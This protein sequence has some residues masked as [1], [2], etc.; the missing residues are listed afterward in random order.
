M[1][2]TI[3]LLLL[4]VF[5]VLA[6]YE[7]IKKREVYDYLNFSLVFIFLVIGIFDSLISSSIEPIKYV[8]FGLLIGFFLGSL[9]YYIGIW[10][11]GDAKFMLGFGASSYYIIN[12]V[13]SFSWVSNFYTNFNLIYGVYIE[14]FIEYFLMFILILDA[15]FILLIFLSFLSTSSN[16]ERKKN[17]F[18]MFLILSFLFIGIYFNFSPSI[19][20]LL[21]FLAFILIFFG[22][23]YLFLSV[24]FVFKKSA[25]HLKKGEILDS[26]LKLK[27][28]T[29][30][31]EKTKFGILSQDYKMIKQ[32][33]EKVQKNAVAD[34]RKILPFG[35]LIALNYFLYTM[36]I[37]SISAFTLELFIFILIFLLISFGVGGVF[38][39]LLVLITYIFNFKKIKLGLKSYEFLFLGFLIV[40]ATILS[41]FSFNFLIFFSFPILYL[42]VKIAKRTEKFLFV[43]PKKIEKIV[44][45][46]WIVEDVKIGDKIYFEKDDFKLGVDEHQLEK[47]NNLSKKNNVFNE[48]LVKD[49]IAFLPPLFI[50]FLILLIFF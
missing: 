32:E 27:N 24:Y 39:C 29:L 14:L 44:P 10:G 30:K 4:L 5:F 28:Y 18:L 47:L 15:I 7:D 34:V 11:G 6:S 19:L 25:F 31:Q 17:L 48:L 3:V 35:A 20:F 46:D 36:K 37:V 2:E 50:G 42:F 1:I 33:D 8:I 12:F 26:D 40:I 16:I 13:S 45:G 49:G 23:E 38:S 22:N 9:L 41:Y 43:K 21:G